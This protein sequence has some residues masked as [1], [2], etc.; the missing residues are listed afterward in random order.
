M[1]YREQAE[2]FHRILSCKE[3]G[4]IS[5]FLAEG[6]RGL[7]VILRI[8]RDSEKG[9]LS[10]DIAK[11]MNISTARVAVALKTLHQKGYISKIP[12]DYDGRKIILKVTPSGEKALS[13]R[14]KSVYDLIETFLAKLTEE[15]AQTFIM[16]A[17]KLFR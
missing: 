13:E 1:G 5:K 6:Y 14:E 9:V 11:T 2:E 16:I 3:C 12:A 4:K 15:E 7:Y 17:K 10:S 8:V